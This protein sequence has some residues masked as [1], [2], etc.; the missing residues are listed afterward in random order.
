MKIPADGEALM[1]IRKLKLSKLDQKPEVS[2]KSSSEPAV[3]ISSEAMELRSIQEYS[4]GV[5]DVRM[6][7]VNQIKE[8][9]DNGEYSINADKL[10]DIL[11]KY[12][13]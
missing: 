7:K 8:K 3:Q 10:A 11:S 9:I 5:S 13:M 2:G 6:D 1:P 12:L 4:R